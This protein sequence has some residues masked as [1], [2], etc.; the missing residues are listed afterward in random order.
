MFA[1]M[2]LSN[3]VLMFLKTIFLTGGGPSSLA[4]EDNEKDDD[5]DLPPMFEAVLQYLIFG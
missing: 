3:E 4:V 2:D 5:V 1:T